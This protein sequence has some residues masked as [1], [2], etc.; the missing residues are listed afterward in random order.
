MWHEQLYQVLNTINNVILYLIGIPFGL[1]LI[2]MLCFWVKKT[3]WPVS[4]KKAKVAII[5]PAHNEEDVI[6]DTIKHLFD[7]QTYSR[8]LYDVYVICHNCT[9]KT[10][11]LA[12]KAGATAVP[13][14]TGEKKTFVADVMNFGFDYLLK[15]D[16]DYEF[17]IRLDADNFVN[18]EFISLMNDA[19]QSGVEYAR[20]YESAKNMT[21]NLYTKAC[22]L[23]YVFDSRFG[24]RVRERWG[25]S[26]HINGCGSMMSKR[27]IQENGGFNCH[28]ISEDTEFTV[29]MMLKGVKGHFVEDAVIYEDLPSTLKDTYHRNKRI[30]SGSRILL[31]GKLGKM[32]FKFFPTL[33]FS[34]L[35][36]FLT[37][38][39]NI[40]CVLLCT[41]LP[42][43][44]IYNVVYLAFCGY[45]MIAVSMFSAAYYHTLFVNTLII[46]GSVLLVLFI[47]CGWFQG[48]LL[49]NLD[50][51]KM[52]A[53]KPSQLIDGAFMYPFFSVI[54]I[55][56]LTL[57]MVSKPKWAKIN[58]NADFTKNKTQ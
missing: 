28:T 35:E 5:I 57:G 15:N 37:F 27:I 7:H 16:K 39:F 19:F 23:Y 55:V 21:Q 52:G 29:N 34:Y 17:Y 56:T 11:E 49:V 2:Y 58:R 4:P 13:F 22:G 30:G 48:I 33:N 36:F 8:N 41:W 44:Y 14:N 12:T 3:T 53:D 51:K 45:G 9:D 26:A 43:F 24:S 42:L 46:I 10:A 40:I 6:Y 31:F 1:Q 18:D 32:F 50:Y 47:F 38:F 25:L 20:G 54:Y